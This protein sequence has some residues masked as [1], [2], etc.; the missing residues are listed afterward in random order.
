MHS[1]EFNTN[2]INQILRGMQWAENYLFCTLW[3]GGKEFMVFKES[4]LKM[5]FFAFLLIFYLFGCTPIKKEGR[6]IVVAFDR[7]DIKGFKYI[8]KVIATS[9]WHIS[10]AGQHMDA[11]RDIKNKAGALGGN[12]VLVISQ[13]FNR[14]YIWIGEV[15][16]SKIKDDK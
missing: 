6:G 3:W 16:N 14:R 12:Y 1:I 2:T 5:I 8:G 13:H 11:Q 10:F 15:Y 9:E 4:L 7:N